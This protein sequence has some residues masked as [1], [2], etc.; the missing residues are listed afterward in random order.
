MI[1]TVTLDPDFVVWLFTG[2]ALLFLCMIMLLS[3]YFST[4]LWMEEM[5][6]SQRLLGVN[7]QVAVQYQDGKRYLTPGTCFRLIKRRPGSD[8]RYLHGRDFVT[9]AYFYIRCDA[10]MRAYNQGRIEKA[11]V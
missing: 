5:E 6:E 7:K 10:F 4:K 11:I 9:G 3:R 1:E 8:A 2:A